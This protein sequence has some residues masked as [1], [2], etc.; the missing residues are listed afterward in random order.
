[1]LERL[2][3]RKLK[4]LNTLPPNKELE[5]LSKYSTKEQDLNK[6]YE[7]VLIFM[8]LVS[9][10][11]T[12]QGRFIIKLTSKNRILKNTPNFVFAQRLIRMG[13]VVQ[14]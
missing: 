12:P 2:Y 6:I 5:F 9:T 11:Y 3:N 1:M 4:N 13:L 8:P 7:K 10:A 14:F